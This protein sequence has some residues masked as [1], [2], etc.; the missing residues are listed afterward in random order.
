MKPLY[1]K[2]LILVTATAC[3][4]VTA[5]LAQT[6]A[7]PAYKVTGSVIDETGKGAPFASMAL[8]KAKDSSLVKGAIT[9]DNGA[10]AFDHVAGGTYIIRATVVGY[11]KSYSKPTAVN[12]NAPEGKVAALNSPAQRKY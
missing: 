3:L 8:L 5:A 11:A 4:V 1:I 12:A 7:R 9:N 10:Y 2:I 6:P